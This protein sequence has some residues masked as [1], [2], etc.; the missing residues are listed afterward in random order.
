MTSRADR[1]YQGPFASDKGHSVKSR[2]DEGHSLILD[3]RWR[4]AGVAA[5][6]V[7]AF[8]AGHL[9]DNLRVFDLELDEED[10]G[11]LAPFEDA[12]PPGDVY[13]A[14][15]VRGGRHAAII[16]YDLNREAGS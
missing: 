3:P 11:Q 7:G 2:E 9:G 4:R 16:K 12:G 14:E 1:K 8:D 15:R 10:L 13:A 5:T 6:I